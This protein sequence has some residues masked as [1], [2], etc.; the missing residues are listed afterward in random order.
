MLRLQLSVNFP[1]PGHLRQDRV[2]R[3]ILLG[4]LHFVDDLQPREEEGRR[5]LCLQR[6]Q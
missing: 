2:R 1:D 4:L 6:L 5:G 3:C